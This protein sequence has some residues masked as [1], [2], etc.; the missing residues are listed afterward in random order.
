MS[1]KY[2][3]L[4]IAAAAAIDALATIRDSKATS[5]TKRRWLHTLITDLRNGLA[6]ANAEDDPA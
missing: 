3:H 2:S 4:K 6:K 1:D 5:T